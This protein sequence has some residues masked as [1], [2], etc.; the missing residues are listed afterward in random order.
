MNGRREPARPI[1]LE[2]E[3]GVSNVNRDTEMFAEFITRDE[4]RSFLDLGTGTGYL[5]IRLALAGSEVTAT[6][7]SRRAQALAERNARRH[8]ISLS[9]RVSDLFEG[10]RGTYDAIAFNPPFSARCDPA[11]V[12]AV[13]EVV[14]RIEPLERALMHHMPRRV[15]EFRRDL[16]RRFVEG[17]VPHLN[18][19]GGL[20]LLLYRNELSFLD[21]VARGLTVVSYSPEELK[22]RNLACV[23]LSLTGAGVGPLDRTRR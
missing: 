1:D 22:R 6:D 16:V 11:L 19:G 8:G 2:S 7:I 10:E 13:K 23:K 4:P 12:V 18:P 17:G 14:R 20:Y 5:A 15:V 21:T 9:V 3:P